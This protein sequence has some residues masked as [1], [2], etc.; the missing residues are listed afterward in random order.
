MIPI[1]ELI[2]FVLHI[3]K[4]LSTII[5][6]YDTWT[7]A[8]IFIIIFLE[9]GLV[10][11]PFLPG[12]SLLFASGSF[13]ALGSLNLG[14]V[15]TV[16]TI[17]AILGDTAN[18]AF[19]YYLGPK[20]FKKENAR[21]LKR[22]YLERTNDFYKRFGKKTIVLARF[23]PIVRTFAP[24]IAGIGKMKYWEFLKFNI[25]GAI[26]WVGLFT[27]SGYYFGTIPIVQENFSLVIIGIIIVSVIPIIIEII[28]SRKKTEPKKDFTPLS[29][30]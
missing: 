11:T 24:F 26:L 10:L 14:I 1:T 5:Q 6:T 15:F 2:G 25:F 18:Y 27:L 3:D 7:Y 21:F 4:Y 29:L 22:E 13:A 16:L 12:D 19:G 9:T 8:F 17:A 30:R 28:R 23:V 20:V